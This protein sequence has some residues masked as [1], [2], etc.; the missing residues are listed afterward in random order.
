MTAVGQQYIQD[1]MNLSPCPH[2][3]VKG[4]GRKMREGIALSQTLTV[5]KTVRCVEERLRLSSFSSPS[6]EI[7]ERGKGV[8]SH[9][10]VYN[11][12]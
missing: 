2:S 4:K 1:V 12:V 9:E 7:R 11:N 6:P 5:K 10:Q 8:R 3:L